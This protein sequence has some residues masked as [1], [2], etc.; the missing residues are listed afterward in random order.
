[1]RE[2]RAIQKQLDLRTAAGNYN[3][4]QDR[5]RGQ[6]QSSPKKSSPRQERQTSGSGGLHS[7][8]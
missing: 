3:D 5:N 2:A 1:M 6:I 7:G 8:Y 4:G